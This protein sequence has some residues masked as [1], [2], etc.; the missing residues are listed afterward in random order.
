MQGSKVFG[1]TVVQIAGLG[2]DSM[3]GHGRRMLHCPHVKVLRLANIARTS[4]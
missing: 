3:L 1:G 2:K 4:D